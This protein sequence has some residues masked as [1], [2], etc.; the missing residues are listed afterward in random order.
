MNHAQLDKFADIL[1][2]KRI[3]TRIMIGELKELEALIGANEETT[4]TI[5]LY[6]AEQDGTTNKLH[7]IWTRMAELKNNT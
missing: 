3:H 4:Q 6:R 1:S 7:N 5:E 2:K